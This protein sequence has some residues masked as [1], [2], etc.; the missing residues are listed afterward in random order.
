M[1]ICNKKEKT[2]NKINEEI[3]LSKSD[4]GFGKFDEYKHIY[5]DLH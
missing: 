3:E 1:Q 5:D 2:M 4:D